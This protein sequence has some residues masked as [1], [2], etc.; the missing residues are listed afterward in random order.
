MMVRMD[1]EASVCPDSMVCLHVSLSV[2]MFVFIKIQVQPSVSARHQQNDGKQPET[3]TNNAT[4]DW[5]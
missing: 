3:H 4:L 2:F 5:T 1:A